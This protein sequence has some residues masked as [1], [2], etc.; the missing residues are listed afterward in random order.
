MI[1]DAFTVLADNEIIEPSFL[2]TASRMVGMRNR[3]VHLYW[4]VDADILYETLQHNLQDF[5]RFQAYILRL[6][7]T[8]DKTSP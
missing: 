2:P 7:Q 3:L 1:D 6:V 4:E 8:Q 5:G